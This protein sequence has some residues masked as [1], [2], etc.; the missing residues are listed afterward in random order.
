MLQHLILDKEFET[1]ASSSECDLVEEA[2]DL[3]GFYRLRDKRVGLSGIVR[4]S[5]G[6]IIKRVRFRGV[7]GLRYG[8][9]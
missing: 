5:Y 3:E 1:E 2:V 4:L 6:L 9:N 7:V 8:L